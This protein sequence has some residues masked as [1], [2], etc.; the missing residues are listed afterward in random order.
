MALKVDVAQLIPSLR[1]IGMR[2]GETFQRRFGFLIAFALEK[3]IELGD[4][5]IGNG[6]LS[7][8]QEGRAAKQQPQ[9]TA[10]A[11]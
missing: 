8:R 11:T 2:R 4:L 6:R 1:G 9:S 7:K 3:P 5:G 10:Q